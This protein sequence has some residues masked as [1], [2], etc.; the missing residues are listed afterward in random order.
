MLYV[1]DTNIC[2]YLIRRHPTEVLQRL[3]ALREGEASMSVV[4]YAELR[5]GLETQQRNR[6]ND[7]RVLGLLIRRI[8]VVPFDE[9]VATHYGVL[10]AA[11]PD[12]GR[13]AMD[14]LIAAHAIA[15][16]GAVLVTNNEA[17]FRDYSGL[18]V[19]NWVQLPTPRC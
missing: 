9:G 2:I 10:R 12:R 18:Q 8:P 17:Y 4:V 13:N 1:L 11:V 15:A 5:A 7:E 6:D 16:G 3:A 19:K 14:R